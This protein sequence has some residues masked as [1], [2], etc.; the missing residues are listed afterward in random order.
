MLKT[1]IALGYLRSGTPGDG[2]SIEIH[3]E[4]HA[5]ELVELPFY[6]KKK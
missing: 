6:R 5:A 2:L 4:L 3:G 1:G